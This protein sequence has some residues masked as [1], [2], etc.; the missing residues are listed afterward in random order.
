MSDLVTPTGLARA[1]IDDLEFDYAPASGSSPSVNFS[2]HTL[3]IS[4]DLTLKK[5]SVLDISGTSTITVEGNLTLGGDAI[6]NIS[7]SSPVNVEGNLTLEDN[8]VLNIDNSDLTIDGD[9]IMEGRS[10]MVSNMGG[11]NLTLNT[12]NIRLMGSS[13]TMRTSMEWAGSR[14]RFIADNITAE[15]ADITVADLAFTANS[16]SANKNVTLQNN[17]L[18]TINNFLQISRRGSALIVNGNSVVDLGDNMLRVVGIEVGNNASFRA[19][20]TSVLSIY[21]NRNPVMIA[22]NI[23][24]GS[25]V[26][27]CSPTGFGLPPANYIFATG[28][29]Y[30]FTSLEVRTANNTVTCANTTLITGA[31]EWNLNITGIPVLSLI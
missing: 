27:V 24:G 14:S 30:S 31:D 6:L 15:N 22:G 20:P 3:E 18:L 12:G 7:E 10:R 25:L 19:N 1:R 21:F 8:A 2:N 23:T 9:L 13:P 16:G 28:N 4:G 17:S 26:L 5:E 29:T 11:V